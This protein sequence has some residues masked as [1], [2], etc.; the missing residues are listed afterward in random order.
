MGEIKTQFAHA[1]SGKVS[2]GAGS[3]TGEQLAG[4]DQGASIA[5]VG[6]SPIVQFDTTAPKPRAE[7]LPKSFAMPTPQKRG[8]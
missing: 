3:I 2:G 6:G 1:V 5:S 8:V 4:I 7:V